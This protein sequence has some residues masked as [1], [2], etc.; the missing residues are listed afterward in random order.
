MPV[1]PTA[2]RKVLVVHGVETGSDSDQHQ[3][4]AI[5][6]LIRDRLNGVPVKFEAALY[7]YED[8]NDKAQRLSSLLVKALTANTPLS[9][10]AG[11]GVDLIGD[12]VISLEDGSTA[13][14]IR[15][16]LRQA[17]LDVYAAGQPLYLVAHS[18]GTVYA[19]DVVNGLMKEADYFDRDSRKTWP[20]QA[21]VTMGSPLGLGLF[22]RSKVTKLGAGRH[23]FRWINYWSRTD[24][25]VSGSFYGKPL[26]GY[27]I[28]ER[29]SVSADTTGWIIQDRVV[30]MGKA[31]LL[32]HGAYWDCAAI[33]DD[34]VTLITT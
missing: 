3:D 21:L 12:V 17:I 14:E 34:L 28:A 31:W 18:L 4:Q 5:D 2:V 8:I 26:Q 30:D 10:V 16:G 1:D 11:F 27:H 7:T 23:F 25:V 24:P 6:K 29:F 15:D 9:S 22:K 33:G 20:V 32:A 19:L 13:A